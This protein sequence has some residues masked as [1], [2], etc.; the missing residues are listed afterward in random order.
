MTGTNRQQWQH[1]GILFLMALLAF[2]PVVMHIHPVKWDMIDCFY[3]WRFH[4]GECLQNGQLPWWNP[5]QDLGY[6]IHADPSSGAWYPMVW[7][8]GSTVGYS[9]WSIGFE[10][11]IH[12]FFAGVGMYFLAKTLKFDPRFALMAGIAYMLSGFFIGNAQHLPYIISACWLPYVLAFYLRMRD[13][14]GGQNSVKAGLF[15]F[16]MIT[17]GYPAITIILFYLLLIFFAVHVL[18]LFQSKQRRE[19]FAYLGRNVLF[20]LTTLLTSA[21]MLMSV[22]VV[23][24]YLSRLGNFDVQQ[25]L[26]SPFSP[27]SFFSFVVPYATTANIQWFNSDLSMRNGY[28]GIFV[29][30][31]FLLGIFRKKPLELRIL[32]WF[33][34]FCLTAA[35]GDYLPVREFL[36]RYVPM[37][38]VFRFPSVFRLFFILGAVLTGVWT[39][40]HFLFDAKEHARRV[41]ITLILAGV[42][43]IAL[44]FAFRLQGHLSMGTFFRLGIF[45]FNAGAF[46][47]QLAVFQAAIQVLLIGVG[48]FL[49]WKIKSPNLRITSFIGLIALDMLIAASLNGPATVYYGEVEA[50]VAQANV[51]KYPHGFPKQSDITIDSAGHLP[52]VGTPY[53]QNQQTFQKQISAEGYN[54]FSFTSYEL[55]ESD[56][57]KLF[58]A[59]KKCHL[60]TLSDRLLQNAVGDSIQPGELLMHFGSDRYPGVYK[61]SKGDTALL[62]SYNAN[63]FAIS[64]SAKRPCLL[65]LHQKDYSDWRAFVNGKETPILVS[66]MNFMTIELPAGKSKVRFVFDNTLVRMALYVSISAL[67]FVLIMLIRDV[68]KGRVSR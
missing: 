54:S 47:A 51:D 50:K 40:Q 36:F 68:V 18:G 17:G 60:L 26:F 58:A 28:F 11:W 20:T 56:F 66:N 67:V 7:L 31:F 23:S 32:F 37:M 49:L 42:G 63:E 21:V 6:P 27:Q 9:I 65:T 35:V 44:I 29:F 61:L 30:L 15:L 53:W 64:A 52:G 3:P 39:I 24:P 57:P 45:T 2:Y 59:V 8:I 46:F 41:F 19:A 38:N 12:V 4:I 5:Y 14:K 16:L 22:A 1:T 34:I 33:G 62:E 43:L 55:L 10:L 25:A 48:T 13:Q